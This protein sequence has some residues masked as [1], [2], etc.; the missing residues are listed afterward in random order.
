MTI[1]PRISVIHKVVIT[2]HISGSAASE[3]EGLD[4]EEENPEIGGP[5][6]SDAA[7]GSGE[8]QAQEEVE[9]ASQLRAQRADAQE[10]VERAAQLRAQ[11]EKVER[12][13]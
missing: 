10:E 3:T 2:P 11:R 8:R 6:G 9:R 7:A 12:L 1:P 5:G 13:A 4:A